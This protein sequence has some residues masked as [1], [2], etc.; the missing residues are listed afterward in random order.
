MTG[1]PWEEPSPRRINGVL[2]TAVPLYSHSSSKN[3][4][5]RRFLGIPRDVTETNVPARKT[6]DGTYVPAW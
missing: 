6:K 5:T 4:A 2:S 3:R 1:K